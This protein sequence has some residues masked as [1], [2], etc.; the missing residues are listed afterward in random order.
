MTTNDGAFHQHPPLGLLPAAAS[1][2][3]GP[4]ASMAVRIHARHCDLCAAALRELEAVGGALLEAQDAAP[5]DVETSL[6]G[7]MARLG[8]RA[9][10]PTFPDDVMAAPEE[11]RS[12]FANALTRGRWTS[13]GRGLHTLELDV[14]GAAHFAERPQLLKIEPGC[15]A[16][17]HS[18]GAVELTLVL[19]GAF[20]DETGLYGPGDLA[21]A[22]YSLTHRPIAE[23]GQTC[24]AYAVSYAPM[25]FTG[26]LGL[27]QRL[28]ATR[29]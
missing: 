14:P 20:R 2:A 23:P 9:E 21:V 7:A 1:G 16:P 6:A 27:A 28:F 19:E 8:A 18:H 3:M 26:L 13:A 4:A 24:L 10:E 25:K 22:T 17:R 11:L 12:A 15:G 5:F 29:S